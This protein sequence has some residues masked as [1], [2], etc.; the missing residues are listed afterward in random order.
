MRLGSCG[1]LSDTVPILLERTKHLPLGRRPR[2][3]RV[4]GKGEAD[5]G[6]LRPEVT[7]FRNF[8]RQQLVDAFETLE[9]PLDASQLCFS[10]GG[11]AHGL[12]RIFSA[13]NS[14]AQRTPCTRSPS[15]R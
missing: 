1:N 12:T 14:Q 10:A 8:L 11:A 2:T 15:G 4:L 3:I 13:I 5:I 6:H 9:L 7:P